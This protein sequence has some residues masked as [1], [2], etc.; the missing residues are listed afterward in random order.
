MPARAT[1]ATAPGK[2][3]SQQASSTKP[4]PLKADYDK[5]TPNSPFQID[6]DAAEQSQQDRDETLWQLQTHPERKISL[7]DVTCC[8]V[9]MLSGSYNSPLAPIHEV[10]HLQVCLSSDAIRPFPRSGKPLQML[11]ARLPGAPQ[12]RPNNTRAD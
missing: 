4:T 10:G 3:A 9:W 7:R 8:F 12:F 11:H 1:T 6:Q 2:I 5:R